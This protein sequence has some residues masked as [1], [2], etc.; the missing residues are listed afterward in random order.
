M[1][2]PSKP[3]VDMKFTRDLKNLLWA[4]ELAARSEKVFAVG[5]SGLSVIRKIHN[6]TSRGL[7]IHRPAPNRYPGLHARIQL[8]EGRESRI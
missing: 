8:F 6:D 3:Y 2:I 5:C 1:S 4:S 7:L